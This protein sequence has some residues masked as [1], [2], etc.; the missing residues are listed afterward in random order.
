MCVSRELR[1]VLT[2]RSRATLGAL[3]SCRRAGLYMSGTPAS[4]QA[5]TSV[6]WTRH[7]LSIT[8]SLRPST[9]SWS[10]QP[11]EPL[12]NSS[13]SSSCPRRRPHILV[14]NRSGRGS[15]ASRVEL[16]HSQNRKRSGSQRRVVGPVRDYRSPRPQQ[17]TGA[18]LRSASARGGQSRTRR[19]SRQGRSRTVLRRAP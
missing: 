3:G 6:K 14:C 9:S 13:S 11:S 15:D 12:P 5:P 16:R 10:T 2:M 19:P 4:G 18:S 7:H 1:S 8:S 17:R